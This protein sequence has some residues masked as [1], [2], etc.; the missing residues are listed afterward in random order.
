MDERGEIRDM[1]IDL[2]RA[3]MERMERQRK[4]MKEK[5]IEAQ[6]MYERKY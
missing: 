2:R 6:K 5:R 1:E 4:H 3:R